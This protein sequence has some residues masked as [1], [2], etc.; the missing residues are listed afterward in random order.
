M[1]GGFGKSGKPGSSGKSNWLSKPETGKKEVQDM[2]SQ[3]PQSVTMDKATQTEVEAQLDSLT[4]PIGPFLMSL[5][6]GV[7][8]PRKWCCL[9]RFLRPGGLQIGYVTRQAIAAVQVINSVAGQAEPGAPLERCEL[10]K[11]IID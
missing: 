9:S 2:S 5:P 6:N 8:Y 1:K 7:T 4:T 11:P 3:T 10:A